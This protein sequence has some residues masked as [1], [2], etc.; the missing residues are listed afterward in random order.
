V[1]I[2][3]QLLQL[4]RLGF[5]EGIDPLTYYLQELYRPGGMEA[6]RYYLTRY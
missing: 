3:R 2:S 5:G 4:C 1:P 6:A